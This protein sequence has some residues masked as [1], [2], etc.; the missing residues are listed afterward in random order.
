VTSHDH[1]N[2]TITGHRGTH[3]ASER[4]VCVPAANLDV[5]TGGA[6]GIPKCR[7]EH[8]YVGG[9]QIDVKSRPRDASGRERGGTDQGVRDVSVSEDRGDAITQGHRPAAADALRRRP[10]WRAAMRRRRPSSADVPLAAQ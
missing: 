9:Q 10:T 6:Q 4:I 5:R 2:R 8:A 3:D 1:V 7:I